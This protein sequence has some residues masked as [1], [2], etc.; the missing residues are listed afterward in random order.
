MRTKLFKWVEGQQMTGYFKLT[1]AF[2]SKWTP[3]PFDCYILKYPT[4]SY[5]PPHRDELQIPGRHYRLNIVLKRGEGGEFVCDNPIYGSKRINLFRPDLELHSVTR[6]TKG[7]RY[8][9]SFGFALPM[10]PSSSG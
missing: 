10:H 9:L 4:G 1:L 5:I 6:V 8:V 3:I 7:T 2:V